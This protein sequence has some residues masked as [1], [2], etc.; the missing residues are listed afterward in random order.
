[1]DITHNIYQVGNNKDFIVFND[2]E[3]TDEEITDADISIIQP[4]RNRKIDSIVWSSNC[5]FFFVISEIGIAL[6][7]TKSDKGHL[8]QKKSYKFIELFLHAPL[9]QREAI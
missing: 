3:L 7:D 8:C 9:K 4:K 2:S 1:M 6:F 5:R